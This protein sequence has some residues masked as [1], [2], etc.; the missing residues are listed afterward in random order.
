MNRASLE[1]LDVSS[2]PPFAIPLKEINEGHDVSRFLVS[3]AY[4]DIMTFVM[5]LNRSLFPCHIE[6]LDGGAMTV[7]VWELEPS[8]VSY[9][10]T[11]RH[12]RTL[13]GK[14]HAIIDE[15]PPDPGPRRFGNVS[16]RKWYD[17]VEDRLGA[18]LDDHLP[19][20]I[21]SLSSRSTIKPQ[22][23]LK[24]YLMGSFGSPQRLDYGTGHELSF[25]AFLGCIWKLGGF[26]ASR[27]G[28]EER[29]IV[30]GVFEP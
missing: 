11:V 13:L 3:Q 30:L 26:D 12:L 16:F 24:S 14:L 25:L 9:S 28:N 17:F 10:S 8:N 27:S 29:G 23:E 5:Q 18:L 15:V 19:A 6:N 21:L 20:S 22:E 7:Q 4:G 2:I 1:V